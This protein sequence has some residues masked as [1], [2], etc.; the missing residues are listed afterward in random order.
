[1]RVRPAAGAISD[2]S[3]AS[4]SLAASRRPIQSSFCCSCRHRSD[5]SAALTSSHKS[6]LC[7]AHTWPIVAQPRAR[8]SRTARG[9]SRG[10]R[11]SRGTAHARPL[12]A[13]ANAS[14][15]HRRSIARSATTV[16]RSA[17]TSTMRR[18][19]DVL[20]EI[21][22]VRSDVGERG[23]RAALL[24]LEAPREIG[25]LEQP[26]LQVAAVDEVH[27][28]DVARGDHRARLLHE[29]VAAVVERH[30]VHD[31][32]VGRGAPER[33]RFRRRRRQRLLRD[34]VLAVGDARRE[35]PARAGEF[36]VVL[37]MTS[38]VRVAP[39]APRTCRT[40]S[41]HRSPR[42]SPAPASRSRRR[43]RRRRRNP[44]RRTAS[45]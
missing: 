18:A 24:R 9:W 1:M 14:A 3:F 13:L 30:R 22:P 34:D 7:P 11:S 4:S 17:S 28:A 5:A 33:V 16:V 23:A 26:V 43:P 45:M 32:G 6:F 42:P 31:A 21:A 38:I 37:W 19:D 12:T 44:R 39:P 15:T 35:S 27:G 10:L 29:R 25:R 2:G 20:R 8:R 40:P 41:A 36:G